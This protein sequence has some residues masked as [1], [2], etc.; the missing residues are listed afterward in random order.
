MCTQG[1]NHRCS[2]HFELVL[3]LFSFILN[4]F[5]MVFMEFG[6]IC[7]CSPLV[8]IPLRG[9]LILLGRMKFGV[10]SLIPGCLVRPKRVGFRGTCLFLIA[11]LWVY[12]VPYTVLY[13][14]LYTLLYTVLS[15]V[16]YTVLYTVL[17]TVLFTVLY[18]VLYTV[19]NICDFL[20]PRRPVG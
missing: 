6:N 4:I 7:Y 8:P 2:H 14:A 3:N 15:A 9:P 5:L 13:T 1:Q 19:Q 18:T 16:L 10:R 17:F 12:T 11:C 20:F